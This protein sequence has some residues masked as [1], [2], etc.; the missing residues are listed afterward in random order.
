MERVAA[1][2]V[3]AWAAVALALNGASVGPARTG[4]QVRARWLQ[5]LDPNISH[6]P[7]TEEEEEIIYQAHEELGNR[8]A[9]I[10]RRLQG[11]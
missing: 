9:D 3:K 1:L 2:G 6:E 7:W 11:R 4:K 10:A 5:H 8:W